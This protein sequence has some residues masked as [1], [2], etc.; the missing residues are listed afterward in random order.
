MVALEEVAPRVVHGGVLPTSGQPTPAGQKGRPE[1]TWIRR[2][3]YRKNYEIHCKIQ[4][5]KKL[6]KFQHP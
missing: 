6:Q 2:T 4:L 5:A 3:K 1:K